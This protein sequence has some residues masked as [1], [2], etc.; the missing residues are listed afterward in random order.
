LARRYFFEAR[1]L[2]VFPAFPEKVFIFFYVQMKIH[3]PLFT[4]LDFLLLDF[5]QFATK[6]SVQFSPKIGCRNTFTRLPLLHFRNGNVHFLGKVLLF[7][8]LRYT[9]I[10]DHFSVTDGRSL[11]F[12]SSIF[13]RE[14]CLCFGAIAA[15]CIFPCIIACFRDSHLEI[16]K[17]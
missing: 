5:G 4:T 3:L 1:S 10:H 16:S 14:P 15:S 12:E 6:D 7:P 2:V 11:S 9:C 17:F 13:I 8:F